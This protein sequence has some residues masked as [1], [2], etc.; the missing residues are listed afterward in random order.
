[1]RLRQP[2]LERR[3][4]RLLRTFALLDRLELVPMH[5]LVEL[6]YEKYQREQAEHL[7]RLR[8][9]EALRAALREAR[10]QLRACEQGSSPGGDVEALREAVQGRT[11][12]LRA[13]KAKHAAVWRAVRASD[14]ELRDQLAYHERLLRRC[15]R[16][17]PGLGVLTRG[18]ALRLAPGAEAL[19]Q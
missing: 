16:G 1:M 7:D 13:A 17:H 18:A 5:R 2:R 11:V 9:P 8:R 4:K 12:A 15:F 14:D 6:A 3:A 19:L 10:R